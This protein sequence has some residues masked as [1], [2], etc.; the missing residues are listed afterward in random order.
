[1]QQQLAPLH[2]RAQPSVVSFGCGGVLGL[3]AKHE[4]F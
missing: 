3:F 1:M 4:G 2:A